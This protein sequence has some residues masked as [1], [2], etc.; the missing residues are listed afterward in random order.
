ML[1]DVIIRSLD[2]T[3]VLLHVIRL[4]WVLLG[5]CIVEIPWPQNERDR[6]SI[7][8]HHP[9]MWL[10]QL[11]ILFKSFKTDKQNR[12]ATKRVFFGLIF[13]LFLKSF[14]KLFKFCKRIILGIFIKSA[15]TLSY[16]G[17][18]WLHSFTNMKII[19]VKSA[20]KKRNCYQKK[21]LHERGE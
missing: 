14:V 8:T 1:L 21:S 7:P 20:K 6:Q 19:H 9:V 3:C 15:N 4:C 17:F 12:I 10:K 2:V 18:K 11:I 16:F 13:Y 5:V